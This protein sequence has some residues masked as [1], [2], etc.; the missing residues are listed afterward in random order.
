MPA[1]LLLKQLAET[2]KLKP[3]ID[4]SYP[5]EHIAE[6]HSFVDA[7]QKKGNV[8]ITVRALMDYG[9]FG[10][11]P[12]RLMRPPSI[13]FFPS[14]RTFVPWVSVNFDEPQASCWRT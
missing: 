6:A 3:V 5:L 2:G 1:L 14:A 13:R 4:R 11:L 12:T 10:K 7:G 8:V 9:L